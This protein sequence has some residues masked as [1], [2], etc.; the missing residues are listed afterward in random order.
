MR[1]IVKLAK[2]GIGK[3]KPCVH[4]GEVIELTEKLGKTQE[5]LDFSA[6][7]NPLGSPSKALAALIAAPVFLAT[8]VV[9]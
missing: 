9:G 7:I 3:L 2:K 6:N 5:I 4:G 8:V 1:S